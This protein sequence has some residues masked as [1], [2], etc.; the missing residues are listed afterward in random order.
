MS[1]RA[2]THPVF[3]SL[4]E[5]VFLERGNTLKHEYVA[6]RIYAMSGGT[7][8][9]ARLTAVIIGTLSAALN[10]GRCDVYSSDLRIRIRKADVNTYPDASVICG[11]PQMDP[12]D[13][14]SAINP[15]VLVEVTSKSTEQYDRGEKFEYYKQIPSLREYVLVSHR[16]PAI[17]VRRRTG[18]RWTSHVARAGGQLELKSV[19]VTLDVDAI[20]QAAA[21]ARKPR[22]GDHRRPS[23][24]GTGRRRPR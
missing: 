2:V 1:A 4:Q 16:E 23:R 20:Y 21:R 17:E 7:P 3:Y 15:I 5:Y 24:K 13:K 11:A 8:E 14:N 6:G 18:R 12:A 22:S 9:H 19:D 10:S